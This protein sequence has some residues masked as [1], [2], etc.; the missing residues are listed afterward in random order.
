MCAEIL[1]KLVK[2]SNINATL[3]KNYELS[4]QYLS[5]IQK[6]VQYQRI[7]NIFADCININEKA[8]QTCFV[9]LPGTVCGNLWHCAFYLDDAIFVEIHR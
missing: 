6:P 3:I 1:S 4:Y 9:L 2:A 7:C 5:A 8:I